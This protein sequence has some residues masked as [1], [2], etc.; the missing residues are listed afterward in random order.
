MFV[1]FLFGFCFC[2]VLF[3][4]GRYPFASSVFKKKRWELWR[5]T[6]QLNV[7]CAMCKGTHIHLY[8]SSLLNKLCITSMLTPRWQ[9]CTQKTTLR[10]LII[11]R[12]TL[13]VLCLFLMPFTFH[14][15]HIDKK[16]P[17]S[18]NLPIGTTSLQTFLD[19]QDF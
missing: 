3:F 9:N 10:N 17:G 7:E 2:F 4:I 8:K 6:C 11:L 1:C 16:Y 15:P 14:H 13:L 12:N 19:P 5:N 18:G